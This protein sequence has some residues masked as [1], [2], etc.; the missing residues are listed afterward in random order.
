MSL[1]WVIVASLPGWTVL[2]LIVGYSMSGGPA[3]LRAFRF[4]RRRCPTCHQRLSHPTCA[5]PLP[6][7]TIKRG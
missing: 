4:R 6:R 3:K 2:G 7:A 5:A 1:F